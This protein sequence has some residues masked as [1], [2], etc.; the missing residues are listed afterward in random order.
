MSVS[1]ER[2]ESL[3]RSLDLALDHEWPQLQRVERKVAALAPTLILPA[4]GEIPAVAT[5]ATDG[6]ESKLALDP[7]RLHVMRVA[8]SLGQ[9]YFEEF[10]PQSLAP[11]EIVRFYFQS[12]AKL[13]RFLGYLEVE[14]E[15]LL[16]ASDYQRSHL[17][18]MLRE[19]MEWAALLKL[20]SQPPARLLIRDGLL[21]SVLLPGRVFD[22]LSEKFKLLTT[23]HGHLLAGISKRSRIVNYLSVAFGLSENFAGTEPAYLRIPPELEREAAPP[24]Y[25]WVN[26]RVMGELYIARLDCGASVPLLPVEIAHWQTDKIADATALLELS[27]RGS[28]PI[29]GYPQP[30]IQADKHARLGGLEIEMLERHL[31]SRVAERDARVAQKARELMLLGKRLREEL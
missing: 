6:G 12:H 26:S 7:I 14:W 10:V 11:E 5:V 15:E 1:N 29:R 4:S 18:Q 24:Q 20:A 17:L 28:F 23:K 3:T 31:L 9:V 25:A 13:Q 22:Q 27:A 8:D 21:R 30:L 2:L 19:L 16:P